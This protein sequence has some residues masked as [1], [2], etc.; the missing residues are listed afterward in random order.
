VLFRLY[1]QS[2]RYDEAEA[3]LGEGLR[4]RRELHGEDHPY[5]AH[6]L[7]QVARLRLRQGRPAEALALAEQAADVYAKAEFK[8]PRRLASTDGVRAVAL[9]ETG[10]V[11]EAVALYDKAIADARGAGVDN[12]VEWPRVMAARAELFAR[13]RPAHAKAAVE[14]ALR[15][16]LE[17]YGESHPGTLRMHE[18][19]ATLR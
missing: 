15:A 4:L 5:Y 13:H 10:R 1:R 7:V 14:D 12:G 3:L 18:L 8:D 11:E 2:G 17:I 9:A 19:A 6:G 16:H